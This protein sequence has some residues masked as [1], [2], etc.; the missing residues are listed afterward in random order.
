MFFGF[1]Q[2]EFKECRMRLANRFKLF[3]DISGQGNHG[4]RALT[5]AIGYENIVLQLTQRHVR[6]E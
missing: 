1:F 5:N 3:A 6:S 2:L 4:V